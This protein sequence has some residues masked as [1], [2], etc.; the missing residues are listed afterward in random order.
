VA[1]VIQRVS[2][3]KWSAKSKAF[4]FVFA[5]DRADLPR[6]LDIPAHRKAAVAEAVG[7]WSFSAHDF[8]DDELLH[9]ALTMLEHVLSM[10]ELEKWRMTAG[11]LTSWKEACKVLTATDELLRFLQ[12][13]RTAYNDFVLYHNFRHV[14]DVLQGVF[15][16][17]FKIGTIPYYPNDAHRTDSSPPPAI[18]SLL[19][20]IDALTLTVAAIG[21]DVG[22]PG[23]N[24]AFLVALNA[25]L[26]QL[27]NDHSVLE[28]FHCAAYSQILRRYW[29]S[30][31]QDINMRKLMIS[32]ILATDMGLHFKYMSDL[33]HLQEKLNQNP[34]AMDLWNAKERIEYKDLVCG[35]LIKCADISNVV[36]N[37]ASCRKTA[38]QTDLF[39]HAFSLSLRNGPVSLQTN[40]PDKP[41][42]RKNSA[43][44][45]VCLVARP[46][47]ATSS[48]CPRVS[49]AL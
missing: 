1:Y 45:R 18:A 6:E 7:T 28:S 20:P 41:T 13:C 5:V 9:G 42:W 31:F 44:P 16:F 33:G 47:W 39:R 22:H 36:S 29:T 10:P 24:N 2:W 3:E 11:E 34:D 17:L 25:P 27:Y 43:S 32:T 14:I 40:S 21:H 26:A 37:L 15:Y 12:A 38:H 49:K 35:L 48:S 46:F 8:T 23:V 19:T 4:S 30:A